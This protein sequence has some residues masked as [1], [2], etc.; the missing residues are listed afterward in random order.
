VITYDYEWAISIAFM[1][2]NET[3]ESIHDVIWNTPCLMTY[4]CLAMAYSIKTGERVMNHRERE[5]IRKQQEAF[6]K[7]TDG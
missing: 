5:V 2:V 1:V 4:K 3:N 7:L 6:R